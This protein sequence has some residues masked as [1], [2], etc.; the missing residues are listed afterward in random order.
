MGG[1]IAEEM[2]F[3]Y[4]NVTSG[5]SSDIEMVTKMAKNMV[6]RYGMSDQ[7]G[8]IAYQ[9]NEEEVLATTILPIGTKIT[10]K[11]TVRSNQAMEFVHIKDSKASGFE[12]REKVSSY[13]YS[14]V[15][16]YQ[17]N[18]DASTEIFIDYLPKGNHTFEYELF[19]TGKG[20][21]TIGTAE[22]ECMYAPMYRGISGGMKVLVR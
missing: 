7:L 12:S 20:S 14:T 1:R 15:S 2:I 22:V 18:K 21:L 13:K 3:G 16:Y 4:D 17:I 11:M 8:P 19:V 5:A 9:E 6:T 10:I